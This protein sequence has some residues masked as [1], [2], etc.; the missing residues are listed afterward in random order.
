MLVVVDSIS[1][2]DKQLGLSDHEDHVWGT[3][4]W[5]SRAASERTGLD[6]RVRV[7]DWDRWRSLRRVA[8]TF[9]HEFFSHGRWLV[10]PSR[11]RHRIAVEGK[12]EATCRYCVDLGHERWPS[13]LERSRDF[14]AVRVLESGGDMVEMAL[15]GMNASAHA[16]RGFDQEHLKSIHELLFDALRCFLAGGLVLCS[17]PYRPA[18]EPT[19]VGLFD[20]LP[21]GFDRGSITREH[22]ELFHSWKRIRCKRTRETIQQLGCVTAEMMGLIAQQIRKNKNRGQGMFDWTLGHFSGERERLRRTLALPRW[23]DPQWFSLRADLGTVR[24]AAEQLLPA[25]TIEYTPEGKSAPTLAVVGGDTPRY[26]GR[27][28]G[29]RFMD[30]IEDA[31]GL[32]I[33]VRIT[34]AQTWANNVTHP[35]AWEYHAAKTG[36]WITSPTVR[37]QPLPYEQVCVERTVRALKKVSSQVSWASYGYTPWPG[38]TDSVIRNKRV[39]YWE[40][41][42]ERLRHHQKVIALLRVEIDRTRAEMNE[43]PGYQPTKPPKVDAYSPPPGG[44]GTEPPLVANVRKTTTGALLSCE[45]LVRE[46]A[47]YAQ[48]TGTTT[49]RFGRPLEAIRESIQ[50]IAD[51]LGDLRWVYPDGTPPRGWDPYHLNRQEVRSE[52]SDIPQSRHYQNADMAQSEGQPTP[53]P[54]T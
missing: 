21:A 9:E 44:E 54:L 43:T 23:S 6:I 48:Q 18:S 2:A 12:G 42:V 27:S 29:E 35:L 34:D 31:I 19:I 15:Q 28:E 8:G 33:P 51:S 41:L 39:E 25:G 3:D 4:G 14:A 7:V 10:K 17:V 40:Q 47:E 49:E 30:I 50:C 45:S 5:L 26:R 13:T 46:I 16:R 20:L 22:V 1:A 36:T 24:R 53:R 52:H 37:V 38:E 32:V 11:R